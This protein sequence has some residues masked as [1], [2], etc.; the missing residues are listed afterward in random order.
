MLSKASSNAL[1]EVDAAAMRPQ[2]MDVPL[3]LPAPWR[4]QG[5]PRNPIPNRATQKPEA[6]ATIKSSHY[7]NPRINTKSNP[8][9]TYRLSA[10][11]EEIQNTARNLSQSLQ[12]LR[13]RIVKAIEELRFPQECPGPPDPAKANSNGEFKRNQEEK[14]DFEEAF[15]SEEQLG[16]ITGSNPQ[17][18]TQFFVTKIISARW[19]IKSG[20]HREESTSASNSFPTKGKS[21][22][23]CLASSFM[24]SSSQQAGLRAGGSE[25]Q[26][27]TTRGRKD[28][29]V[30]R[31]NEGEKERPIIINM[32]SA[33]EAARPR[34]LA[35]GLFLSTLLV[36]SDVL[37][38]RMKKVWRVRG[39]TEASQIEA[40][41]GRKFII[42]FSEEGD[43]RHAVCGGPWQYKLDA[44]LV[45]AMESGADPALVP[46]THVPMWVQFR[47]IP[48][49]LLTKSLAWELGWK[50][51]TTLM[52]DND[53]RGNIADKF[54]RARIQLPLYTALRNKIILEDEVTGEE[55][56]VQIC[57]ER[58]PNFC[59]FCGY[60][61]HME[62]RCD[63]PVADRKVK[64][65]MDMRV[66][67]VH[68]EYPQSWLLPDGM[69]QA[70]A[71]LL[72]AAPWRAS[73][74]TPAAN[75]Q[76]IITQVADEVAKLDVNDNKSSP[77]A[78]ASN[79]GEGLVPMMKTGIVEAEVDNAAM[80]STEDKVT[81]TVNLKA[82]SKEGMPDQE[83]LLIRL[84]PCASDASSNTKEA[85]RWKRMDR[86]ATEVQ[87][88][89]NTIPVPLKHR[90]DKGT[91]QI[92]RARPREL[93]GDDDDRESDVKKGR[94]E[95]PPLVV[96][97]GEEG[98]RKLREAELIRINKENEVQSSMAEDGRQDENDGE[99]EK[100][101]T[102]PG[103]TGKLSGASVSARQ[104]P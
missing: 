87:N 77:A 56:K 64:F 63:L 95:V 28:K 46:F 57:Y 25:N 53:S 96:C 22:F 23:R 97:L 12:R 65:S 2:R 31:E 84:E 47:N 7:P 98:L 48:F 78:G 13:A 58:L 68:F 34:F 39:H 40:D 11:E 62:A 43:R 72:P 17:I 90:G 26:L 35:V 1:P 101:A 19:A 51:G 91:D 103:A 82:A 9:K 29:A 94:Y 89:I 3:P 88:N 55:V 59:L 21:R 45:E 52:I 50:I 15:Q 86:G 85:K 30:V 41:E 49:Y 79:K 60:I 67:P 71:Q 99:V 24:A 44:F 36:S 69:G 102:G 81:D 16:T 54:L 93:Q 6:Q 32:T 14:E 73:K 27:A 70:H 20:Y 80:V 38:Q 61:G 42:E 33:R 100:A 75:H 4:F 8:P 92:N 5:D 37:M 104:E 83:G 10:R 76:A 66:Q 18:K 74:P